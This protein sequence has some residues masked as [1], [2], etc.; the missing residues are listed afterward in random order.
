MKVA[1]LRRKPLFFPAQSGKKRVLLPERILL[2]C[3]EVFSPIRHYAGTPI[4]W[5]FLVAAPLRY[6]LLFKILSS[7]PPFSDEI[8]IA[9]FAFHVSVIDWSHHQTAEPKRDLHY[10]HRY[11]ELPSASMNPGSNNPRIEEILEFVDDD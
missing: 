5:S 8:S 11:Q 3:E 9:Q 6:D 7:R 4:R 1:V 2:F 10:Q